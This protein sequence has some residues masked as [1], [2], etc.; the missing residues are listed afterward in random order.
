[1]N[2]NYKKYI[3]K[4]AKKVAKE[5]NFL[6]QDPPLILTLNERKLA[7]LHE[8]DGIDDLIATDPSIE[9]ILHYLILNTLSLNTEL[10]KGYMRLI[11]QEMIMVF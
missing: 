3:K 6:M 1:M 11:H 8:P 7:V 9:L 5:N 4:A 10:K 2:S